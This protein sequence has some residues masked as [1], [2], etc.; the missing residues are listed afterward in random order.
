MIY[1]HTGAE[2]IRKVRALLVLVCL[3]VG[4]W[5]GVWGSSPPGDRAA[6][7]ARFPR[8]PISLSRA[9]ASSNRPTTTPNITNKT[10]QKQAT[11]DDFNRVFHPYHL[12]ARALSPC[13][14]LA[15]SVVC[16][17]WCVRFFSLPCLAPPSCSPLACD[18]TPPTNQ[19]KT[20]TATPPKK[21]TPTPG[22]TPW[23]TP[24]TC[25]TPRGTRPGTSAWPPTSAWTSA[26]STPTPRRRCVFVSACVCLPVC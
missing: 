22:T 10:K 3:W 9:D 23:P 8:A 18:L 26:S 13:Y 1:M 17:S 25:C 16:V 12:H 14:G 2:P 4:G 24:R 6:K 11:M 21:T 5:F 7:P 19:L 15:E 20:H